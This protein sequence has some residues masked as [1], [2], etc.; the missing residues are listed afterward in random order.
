MATQKVTAHQAQTSLMTTELNSLADAARN[1]TSSA[2]DNSSNL[3][4][5]ATLQLSLA[6]F[7]PT[8]GGYVAI[9]ALWSADGGST[10]P[11]GSASVAPTEADL[12]AIIPVTAGSGVTRVYTA[13]IQLRGDQVHF[14]VENQTGNAFNA[15]GNTLE[16][17]PFGYTVA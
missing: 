6:S 13:E 12:V 10:F 8:S 3:W 7:T 15:S 14:I 16:I 9:F 11:T 4:P 5:A 1:I 2:Y 17:S